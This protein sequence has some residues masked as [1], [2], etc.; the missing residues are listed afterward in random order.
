[1]TLAP[2]MSLAPTLR[3][4]ARRVFGRHFTR[5][6]GLIPGLVLAA[7]PAMVGGISAGGALAGGAAPSF[8]FP[9]IDGGMLDTAQW[10]GQPVLVVNTASRCG[11]TP[12]YDDLQALQDAYQ[13]RA[14]VLAVPS[15][16]FR[17]ELATNEEVKS[18]CEVN[19]GLTLP[20]TTIQH[21]ATGDL[22]PFYAWTQATQGFVPGWN[23]N[24]VLI[25]PDGSFIKAWGSATRPDAPAITTE[26][27]RLLVTG[28]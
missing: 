24:K 15:D 19:F 2:I 16:D 17:Q 23:F 12:Q 6:A 7:A 18:F 9:S 22:H 14:V 5:V 1:M 10:R 4:L 25:G 21:V 27:D 3:R 26:I 28:G 20:M 13:G 8:T 11:Y